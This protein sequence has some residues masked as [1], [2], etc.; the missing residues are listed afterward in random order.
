MEL[1]CSCMNYVD[2]INIAHNQLGDAGVNTLCSY[3]RKRAQPLQS[4]DLTNN[5][6]TEKGSL[7]IAAVV[8][9]LEECS[10][11]YLVHSD[12][13]NDH[14]NMPMISKQ[15]PRIHSLFLSNN[16]IGDQAAA[17]MFAAPAQNRIKALHLANGRVTA[18][19]QHSLCEALSH[20]TS[21]TNV[22]LSMNYLNDFC[23]K[24]YWS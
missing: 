16:A 2:S 14:D 15:S 20:S 8:L 4:L 13:Q 23:V 12:E 21:L 3:L 18:D 24:V 1:L 5:G 10:S 17:A 7:E 11:E 6:I 9:G 22:D 19:V